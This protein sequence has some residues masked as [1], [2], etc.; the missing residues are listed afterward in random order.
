MYCAAFLNGATVTTSQVLTSGASAT[1]LAGAT[2]A[3][4]VVT[5]LQAVVDYD[6][7]CVAATVGGVASL[8]TALSATKVGVQ[9]SCC[10]VI[11]F[12]VAPSYIYGDLSKYISASRPVFTYTLSATPRT[13]LTVTPVVHNASTNAIVASLT[14]LPSSVAFTSSSALVGQFVV[15]G[16]ALLTGSVKIELQLAG[17]SAGDFSVSDAASTTIMSS[18]T[19]SP[20]PALLNAKFSDSGASITVAFDSATNRALITALSFPCS[21]LFDFVGMTTTTCSWTSSTTVSVVFNTAPAG[22]QLVTVGGVLTLRGSMVKAVCIAP[23]DCTSYEAAVQQSTT[24][25]LPDTPVVPKV[26]LRVP[27]VI[28]GCD[29]FSIDP[30]LSSGA[31]GRP[32]KA[33]TW[34]ATME[35]A[36]TGAVASGILSVLNSYGS[37]ITTPISI[38]KALVS[39]ARYTVSLTLTNFLD[40]RSSASAIFTTDDNPNLP[41]TSILGPSVVTMVPSSGLTLFTSTARASCAISSSK[42]TYSW[43]VTKNGVTQNIVSTSPSPTKFVLPAYALSTQSVYVVTFTATA[44][45]STNPDYPAIAASTSVT[46]QVGKGN[47]VASVAGGSYRSVSAAFTAL[48]LDASGSYDESYP[49][50]TTVAGQALSFSWTCVINSAANYG[51]SCADKLP[52]DRTSSTL[53]ITTSGLLYGELY[54]FTVMTAAADG[55]SSFYEVTVQSSAGST[56][57]SIEDL[58]VTKV[59]PTKKLILTGAVQAGYAIDAYWEALVDGVPLTF[60]ASTPLRSSFTSAQVLTSLAYPLSVPANTFAAGSTVAFRLSANFAGD[61]TKF[62]SYSFVSVVMNAPPTGGA[63]SVNPTAGEALSQVF[64]VTSFSWTDDATDFPLAYEFSYRLVATQSALT[65]QTKTASNVASMTLPAG[66]ESQGNAIAL[67]STVYDTFLASTTA[68][69]SVVV[70]AAA[71]VDVSAYVSAQLAS[72]ASSGDSGA[73][74]QVI[75]NAASSINTV[76]CSAANATFCAALNRNPCFSTPQKCSACL[77]GYAGL[78]GDRNTKCRNDGAVLG[79][80][81]AACASN[82][83]CAMGLCASNVCEVPI[84]ECPSATSNVCSGHGSCSYTDGNNNPYG[85]TCTITDPACTAKCTCSSGFG[86]AACTLST[87]ELLGRDSTRASLCAAVVSIGDGDDVSYVLLDSLISSLFSAY[88]P[89]E[90]VSA[91]SRATCQQALTKLAAFSAAGY[92]SA[93]S[94]TLIIDVAAKFV[95]GSGGSGRRRLASDESG[96]AV[97]TAVSGII[98]GILSSLANG[99][100]PVVYANS[101]MELTV[102]KALTS[103]FT[104]LAASAGRENYV[105]LTSSAASALQSDSGYIK[106]SALRWLQSPFAK[107]SVLDAPLLRL[108]LF[109]VA[110]PASRR[111]QESEAEAAFYIVNTFSAQQNFNF[112]LTIEQAIAIGASNFTIPKCAHYVDGDF[113]ECNGCWVSTY[114]NDN[115]TYACPLSALL[116]SSA[117][118]RKLQSTTSQVTQFSTVIAEVEPL[119]TPSGN[120]GDFEINWGKQK[121]VLAFLSTLTFII[122][123]GFV[124]F[125]LLDVL[126]QRRPVASSADP[127]AAAV[128]TDGA[129]PV[130]DQIYAPEKQTGT[131]SAAVPILTEFLDSVLIASDLQLEATPSWATFLITLLKHHKYTAVFFAPTQKFNRTLRW[132]S[133]TMS[134]LLNLFF[135]TVFFGVFYP[136]NGLCEDHHNMES[137]LKPDNRVTNTNLCSW[138][139]DEATGDGSCGINKPP[140]TFVY[141]IVIVMVV[142]VIS[143]PFQVAYDY[144]LVNVCMRRPRFEDWGIAAAS[145][146]GRNAATEENDQTM[147][148]SSNARTLLAVTGYHPDSALDGTFSVEAEAEQIRS[149]IGEQGLALDSSLTSAMPLTAARVQANTLVLKL[150]KHGAGDTKGK[151][152]LLL[153]HFILEQF[154]TFKQF[155]LRRHMFDF[156]SNSQTPA[157]PLLWLLAWFWVILSG[158]F[159]LAWAFAWAATHRGSSSAD[160]GIVLG[161]AL[162]QDLLVIQ[163]F[164]AWVIYLLSMISIRSQL[165]DIYRVL[166]SVGV[167]HTQDELGGNV[168]NLRVCQHVSPACRAAHADG[169]NSLAAATILR[170]MDDADVAAC[171]EKQHLRLSALSTVALA[172]PVAL[173]QLS[174]VVGLMVLG[175]LLPAFFDAFLIMNRYF[176]AGANLFILVPYLFAVVLCVCWFLLI[177]PAFREVEEQSV[178]KSR[179]EAHRAAVAAQEEKQLSLTAVYGEKESSV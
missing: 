115:V 48:T 139:I 14:V 169:A 132:T 13:A 35:T 54:V 30:S 143:I 102:Y 80:T 159:F 56:F 158:A 62:T 81:G 151:E 120:S 178:A 37:V 44:S 38:P 88:D 65:V 154:S 16:S 165:Q 162:A 119:A 140:R 96:S 161:T 72:I 170:R 85:R 177:E 89:N 68:T 164:R 147:L 179:N 92:L 40:Q 146:M 10:N 160:W 173:S 70:T 76:D 86:G 156:T 99:E 125:C 34:E 58:T 42:I 126:E 74:S 112:S 148:A 33:V 19:Q 53:V 128:N 59:N 150:S 15:S 26:V 131:V 98:A 8:E 175:A 57:T 105:E 87:T 163:T 118:R 61:E 84:L 12:S 41:A 134:F 101:Q 166:L 63:V 18:A 52:T 1:Y 21:D 43:A 142:V 157:H 152:I 153:Q 103:N 91:E 82:G 66:Q 55:R 17:A 130:Y 45:A 100:A 95:Q 97:D 27:S 46:V 110:A 104:T 75:A 127:S 94:T 138:N 47:V 107:S 137:C 60:T 145:W 121:I 116:D 50:G 2:S 11:A 3:T 7:Y 23:A 71:N 114:T 49:F 36:T 93:E 149:R 129:D 31:G 168:T 6:A 174:E 83:D 25:Q 79:V 176:Y 135:V 122:L 111:T 78:S 28:S 117:T 133:L 67:I 32:W 108:E 51:A 39:S 144:L 5:G 167:A 124:V 64:T 29:D 155:V 109:D 69:T 90:V 24:V 20:A 4:V 171:R 9:T 113:E 172:L 73:L 136:D 106:A 22:T 77:D 141:L 123:V